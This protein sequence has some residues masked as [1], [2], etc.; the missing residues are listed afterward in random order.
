[1]L[2]F[3]GL[4]NPEEKYL[5]TKHNIGFWAIDVFAKKHN[6]EFKAGK[7]NFIFAKKDNE[8]ILVKPSKTIN[9]S[10]QI[11]NVI[12]DNLASKPKLFFKRS[13]KNINGDDNSVVCIPLIVVTNVVTM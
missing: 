12:C 4:G 1:M 3:V 10:E 7:G 8:Y 6:L 11:P 13:D 9:V 5:Q 2:I